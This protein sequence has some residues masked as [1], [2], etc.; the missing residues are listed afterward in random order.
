MLQR[1]AGADTSGK[2]HV[3]PRVAE[4]INVNGS[5]TRAGD[6]M[7]TTRH[8]G[9]V[10]AAPSSSYQL[11]ASRYQLPATGYQLV[12]VFVARLAL[13]RGAP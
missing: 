9:E 1:W 8:T 7:M 6:V 12:S 10:P 11:R 2:V 3:G 13:L 4:A 5:A